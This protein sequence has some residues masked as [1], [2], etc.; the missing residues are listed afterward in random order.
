MIDAVVQPAGGFAM[1]LDNAGQASLT[2]KLPRSTPDS[3]PHLPTAP[4][5]P[6]A[7]APRRPRRPRPRSALPH[8]RRARPRRPATPARRA[9]PLHPTA[10]A[11]CWPAGSARPRTPPPVASLKSSLCQTLSTA[12][13][14]DP[15][16]SV[17]IAKKLREFHDLDM[18]GPR[19]VSLWQRLRRWLEEARGS[20]SE[21][22]S[23]Q[24][25]LD[26]LGD[27]IAVLEKTLSGVEQ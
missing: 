2:R 10:P 6:P 16:I 1:P 9:A 26:K 27:E 3:R 8:P 11:P 21:E 5:P 14:R 15:E 4:A 7:A 19:D 24:Y 25:Q 18:P 13:L 23:N 20:C 17:L 22:E 12:D